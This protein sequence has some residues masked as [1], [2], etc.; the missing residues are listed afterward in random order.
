LKISRRYQIL[1]ELTLNGVFA[2]MAHPSVFSPVVIGENVYWDGYY[3]SNP[4]FTYL[5]REG[6]EEV[7]LVRLVQ[8]RRDEVGQDWGFIRDRTEEIIQTT[9]LNKEIQAYLAMRDVWFGNRDQIKGVRMS[10][11]MRKF[12]SIGVFHEIRLL[13]PG[14]IWE[15]GYAYSSFVDKLLRLGREVV[16]H[17]MGFIAAYRK[18]PSGMQII[19]EI[20]F[21]SEQVESFVIDLDALLFEAQQDED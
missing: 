6:C 9:T 19:S 11:A 12:D 2:S 4:P 18:A 10:M 17:R 1:H 5:F 15:Q 8:T 14:N 20:D 3:T 13:K 7:I 16:A 21:E